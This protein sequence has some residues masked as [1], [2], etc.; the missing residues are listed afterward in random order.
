MRKIINITIFAIAGLA[1]LLS[2]IFAVEFNQD[3]I[4]KFNNT[5]VIKAN[6][7]QMLSDLEN[8][9]LETL[10]NFIA[11]YEDVI[12]TQNAELK[13]QKFQRDLFYTFIFHLNDITDKES[14]DNFKANF[15][16]YSQSMFAKA[17][18]K[19]FFING[20]NK[21]K[22]FSDKQT[23]LRSLNDDYEVVRY[24]YLEKTNA[25]K[26]ETNLLKVAGD[27]NAA[28]SVSKKQHDLSELKKD[29]RSYKSG[30][31]E[32][33]I[34]MN[35][36]YIFF[37]ATLAAMLLFLF[38]GVVKNLKSNLGLMLGMGL[39][40]ILLFIG[41]FIASPELSPVAIKEKLEPSNMKWI[42]AGIFTFYCTFFGAIAAIFY[43][44]IQSSIKKAN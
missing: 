16:K 11:K 37:F 3:T 31:I 21:V 32:L 27:I 5:V 12:T 25:I 43:T 7:P 36:F 14:F 18:N 40:V 24:N 28:I 41:Y 44:I 33:N 23:Y 9:T 13:N 39:L 30:S 10:P 35:L 17:D 4:E 38:W 1:A 20:F 22:S 19:E 6:N 42:G 15:Q 29:I 26:A 8:A 34:T 2:L